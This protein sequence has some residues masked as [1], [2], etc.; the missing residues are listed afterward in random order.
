[1]Q[2]LNTLISK[3]WAVAGTY[4]ITSLRWWKSRCGGGEEK[5]NLMPCDER[6]AAAAVW[7]AVTVSQQSVEIK[8]ISIFLMPRSFTQVDR[9]KELCSRSKEL[10]ASITVTPHGGEVT[11]NYCVWWQQHKKRPLKVKDIPCALVWQYVH[12]MALLLLSNVFRSGIWASQRW[13]VKSEESLLERRVKT[14]CSIEI[15]CNCR[16]NVAFHRLHWHERHNLGQ[17]LDLRKLSL[18]ILPPYCRNRFQSVWCPS[19]IP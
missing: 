6:V 17:Q 15:W 16:P 7:M 1:M 11:F 3:C 18:S 8:V 10:S 14:L 2:I 19:R 4:S 12:H 13:T 5:N 9:L